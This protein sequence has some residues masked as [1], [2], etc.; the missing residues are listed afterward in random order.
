MIPLSASAKLKCWMDAQRNRPSR[1]LYKVCVHPT[2]AQTVPSES[3][4]DGVGWVGPIKVWATKMK[5]AILKPLNC[6][7]ALMAPSV[8]S[9]AG[10]R[11]DRFDE[12][13][14]SRHV[15]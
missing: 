15:G 10:A 7:I 3:A 13:A 9:I 2:F 5:R 11:A 12:I 6:A 4:S 8:G 1:A 14:G